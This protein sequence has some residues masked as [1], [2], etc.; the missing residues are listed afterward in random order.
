MLYMV[1]FLLFFTVGVKFRRGVLILGGL[2]PLILIIFSM[3]SLNESIKIEANW[4]VFD[5]ISIGLISLS[6]FF[7]CV[8]NFSQFFSV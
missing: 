2:I 8:N 1:L 4:A 7:N 3:Y 6:I 5:T